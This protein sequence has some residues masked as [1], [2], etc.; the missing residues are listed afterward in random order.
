MDIPG[1]SL[2]AHRET[3][4]LI[5]GIESQIQDLMIWTTELWKRLNSQSQQISYGKVRAP[6]KRRRTLKLGV[7]MTRLL[8]SKTFEPQVFLYA[9]GSERWSTPPCQRLQPPPSL[10]A[11]S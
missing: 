11:V 7:G 5:G 10:L 6:T 4:N 8:R 3:L 2:A 9:L 1:A